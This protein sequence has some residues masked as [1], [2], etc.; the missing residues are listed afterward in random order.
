[1]HGQK[2]IKP[3]YNSCQIEREL[4]FVVSS[5]QQFNGERTSTSAEFAVYALEN[6]G[7]FAAEYSLM[8][9]C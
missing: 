8:I 5:E 2:N 1:M 7:R 6:S 3:H 9:Q 4:Y